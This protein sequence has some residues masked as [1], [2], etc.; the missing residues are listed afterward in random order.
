MINYYIAKLY[1]RHCMADIRINDVP[2]LRQ[3]ID[4]ELT[5]EMPVNYLIES[6]GIQEFKVNICPLLG[7]LSLHPNAM[8]V[9]EIWRYDGSDFK[10]IPIEK[11]CSSSL[12]V[13]ET[14]GVIPIKH[15]R[16][17]FIAEVSYQ[18]KRW[19][20][21]EKIPETQNVKQA[22]IQYYQNISQLLARKQYNNFWEFVRERDNSINI[23]LSLD[24]EEINNQNHMMFDY[25]D[26]GFIVQPV[27]DALI[28]YYA[29]G[30]IVALLDKN[31]RSALQF[32]NQD[33]G[34]V[35]DIE[36]L[37]GIKKGYNNFSII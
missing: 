16:E 10:I 31:L 17:L 20:N 11:I 13:D 36:L 35:M 5:S 18:I 37:L 22:V 12:S 15:H 25:L 24:E 8:C 26:N 33:N 21:C 28:H 19:S 14:E 4:A 32:I 9:V 27:K 1:I 29:N 23:A 2:L 30:R 3:Y 7:G 6:S 34:E